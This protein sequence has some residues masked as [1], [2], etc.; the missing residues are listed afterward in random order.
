M[1]MARGDCKEA[2]QLHDLMERLAA[3]LPEEALS[4]PVKHDHV[5]KELAH[6]RSHSSHLDRDELGVDESTS[7][8]SDDDCDD[9][10]GDPMPIFK[11]PTFRTKILTQQ[12][13]TP[14]AG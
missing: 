2:A 5:D 3:E 7:S 9:F 4:A 11:E 12:C 1:A 6:D 8:S 13:N 10:I 14:K